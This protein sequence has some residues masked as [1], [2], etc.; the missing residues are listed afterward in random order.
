MGAEAYFLRDNYEWVGTAIVKTLDDDGVSILQYG[1]ITTSV[2][3]RVRD[4]RHMDSRGKSATGIKDLQDDDETAYGP[5]TRARSHSREPMEA[6]APD[7][8]SSDV[9]VKCPHLGDVVHDHP[10]SLRPVPADSIAKVPHDSE[11]VG[12]PRPTS[13]AED[14]VSSVEEKDDMLATVVRPCVPAAELREL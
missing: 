7:I 10:I 11:G 8:D 2:F 1:R 12:S 14:F 4:L 6:P 3:N 13:H 9:P 5:H